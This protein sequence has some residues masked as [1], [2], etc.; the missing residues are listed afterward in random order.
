MT[1]DAGAKLGC[2]IFAV[3]WILVI[4][5]TNLGLKDG[6]YILIPVIG[7]ASYAVLCFIA[8]GIRR[9][10]KNAERAR[11]A[12]N[13]AKFARGREEQ[14]QLEM[15][16]KS[17]IAKRARLEELISRV[18][19]AANSLAG[20]LRDS[21]NTM[22]LAEREFAEGAFVPFWDA[23]EK[24]VWHLAQYDQSISIIRNG[25]STYGAM[26]SDTTG[27]VA[28]FSLRVSGLP[29][30]RRSTARLAEIVRRAQKSYHFASIYQQR[31]TN[32]LLE[33][34]FANLGEALSRLEDRIDRGIA[35]LGD[36]LARTMADVA[37]ARAEDATILVADIRAIHMRIEESAVTQ[38]EYE[39]QS[40]EMLDNI[41]N[42]RRPK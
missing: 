5:V 1:D 2:S 9:V 42:R 29:E 22:D 7:A 40:L 25:A 18:G 24:A 36:Q 39:G 21:A 17:R 26:V 33:T 15:L 6:P 4:V 12:E 11:S 27:P 14:R 28:A 19:V 16:E 3:F 8:V 31:R 38:R 20:H 30:A 37:L 23:V 32:S 10:I 41:Q 13:A 35:D 34:G